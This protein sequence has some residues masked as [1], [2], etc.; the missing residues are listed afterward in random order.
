MNTAAYVL[1]ADLQPVAPGVSGELY[2]AGANLG[3]GYFAAPALSAASF[4]PDPFVPGARM[5]RTGDRVR[6]NANGSLDYQGR[7]DFQV[8]L[9]GFRIELG[10]IEALL[11]RV[12]GVREAAVVL[13]GSGDSARLVAYYSVNQAASAEPSYGALRAHLAQHL[14]DYMLPSQFVR[15]DR[16]PLSPSGKVCLLYTSPSP[17]D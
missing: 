10:E 13:L 5:Y 2:L 6:R 8:K 15:L 16:L 11:V 12:A 9:R 7:L 4:L 14:P 3:R 17:R 1:D